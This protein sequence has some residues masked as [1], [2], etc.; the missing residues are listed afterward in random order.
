M[1]SP[2]QCRVDQSVIGNKQNVETVEIYFPNVFHIKFPF[3]AA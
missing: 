2:Q 1:S 3:T